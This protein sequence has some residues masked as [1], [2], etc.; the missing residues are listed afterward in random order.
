MP[1]LQN[2][3]QQ[4][5]GSNT[6]KPELSLGDIFRILLRRKFLILL[7]MFIAIGLA[8]VYSFLASPVF[9]AST[10]IK[11]E[12]SDQDNSNDELKKIIQFRSMDEVE[13]E[14]EILKTRTVL[15]KV[16]R[17]LG[18]YCEIQKIIRPDGT[19]QKINQSVTGYLQLL[20][21]NQDLLAP[22]IEFSEFNPI[23]NFD[24]AQFILKIENDSTVVLSNKNEKIQPQ[25]VGKLPIFEI[26]HPEFKLS[27]SWPNGEPGSQILFS[28]KSIDKTCEALLK[29]ISVTAVR[30]TSVFKV[31]ARSK[32]PALAEIIANTIA[33]KFRET[34]LEQKRQTVRYSYDF[35]DR[36]LEETARKLKIAEKDLSDFKSKNQI[37]MIDETSRETISYMSSLEAEKN[38][39]DLELAEYQD[40][41]ESLKNEV[42]EKSY[43]DQTF[44]T[45]N[46]KDSNNS[47]FSSL[48]QQLSNAEL[49]RLELL[50]KRT[51]K[52]PDVVAVNK[53]IN[54]IRE[55]LAS[56][57]Q[58]TITSYE[59]II[60]SLRKKRRDLTD[61]ISQYA[62]KIRTLPANE[63]RLMFLMREKNIHEK[64]FTLLLDKREELR[65]AE[66]SKLQDIVV[67]DTAHKPIKPVLP[68]KR[69]NLIFGFILGLVSGL[70][71]AFWKEFQSNT[72]QTVEELENSFRLPVLAVLPEF[73]RKLK[74]K[75]NHEFSLKNHFEIFKNNRLGFL[76]SYRALRT[77]ILQLPV[78]HNIIF[79]T[80]CEENTGKTTVISNLAITLAM[81]GKKVLLI[82]CDLK[83]PKVGE[84]FQVPEKSIGLTKFLKN[85]TSKIKIFE[86]KVNFIGR[87]I[88]I[89]VLPAGG[90]VENSSELLEK[91]K[92][93][94]LINKM[95]PIY[96][97]VLIDTP[98]V[99]KTVDGLVLG[100]FIKDMIFIVRPKFTHKKSLLRAIRDFDEIGV[101][102]LGCVVNAHDPGATL[103]SYSYGYD[104][105]SEENTKVSA[106]KAEME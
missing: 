42:K 65:M 70:V 14:M 20:K 37:L 106:D 21:E 100:H 83:K 74:R 1:V 26:Q 55:K 5:N 43:F 79:V 7:C 35:V 92:F 6:T 13:T 25:I 48:M 54:E 47:P 19:T 50:Q 56:Y 81:A 10:L 8:G 29:S 46:D 2:P 69:L 28:L 95:A 64:L 11:K 40:R 66:L 34:R 89:D 22:R 31:A 23:K 98:P 52:H 88:Q 60:N 77:K 82:D 102:S 67:L 16:I 4:N 18:L 51:E 101:R 85:N 32:S 90:H 49:E 91:P 24:E 9:E 63:A 94:T 58:N 93:T 75:I 78:N 27:F 53:R 71:L 3:N 38:K 12:R 33:D 84:F 97:Y 57:N 76:E 80:S 30:N 39:T 68:R 105:G 86:S 104:Y 44:L 59:I 41:L 96:D 36:Q 61:L 103:Y 15:E 87:K 17:E 99:T 62:R 45:P 73:S 72:I